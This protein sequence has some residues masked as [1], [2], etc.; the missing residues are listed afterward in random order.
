MAAAIS[1]ELGSVFILKFLSF[2]GVEGSYA[3]GSSS[4]MTGVSFT[5][6]FLAR[7]FEGPLFADPLGLPLA[8]GLIFSSTTSGN[9]G[10]A[11]S[12]ASGPALSSTGSASFVIIS[13]LFATSPG[14]SKGIS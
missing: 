2:L 5:C 13:V 12:M 14:I 4:S 6:A 3:A 8:F 7:G 10:A 11:S 9:G 1:L